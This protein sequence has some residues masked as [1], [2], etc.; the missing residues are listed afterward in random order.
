[1]PNDFVD[2][3]MDRND[4]KIM[5]T[6]IHRIKD[7]V[8]KGI[9]GKGKNNHKNKNNNHGENTMKIGKRNVSLM[10][11]KP[12]ISNNSST[13]NSQRGIMNNS[14]VLSKSR[15][16]NQPSLPAIAKNKE[17]KGG[18]GQNGAGN[19]PV[20]VFPVSMGSIQ[21]IL[22]LVRSTRVEGNMPYPDTKKEIITP[23]TDKN[24]LIAYL[25]TKDAIISLLQSHQY[26]L[27]QECAHLEAL[28]HTKNKKIYLHRHKGDGIFTPLE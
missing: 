4:T 21:G 6:L 14:S 12:S 10:S 13:L 7:R 20:S 19:K 8:D 24:E 15:I 26:S 17:S 25:T 28:I 18:S 11:A 2:R 1:M 27:L 22:E 3:M 23:K 5:D 9:E 16:S